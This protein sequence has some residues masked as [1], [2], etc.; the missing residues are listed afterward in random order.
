MEDIKVIERAKR[1]NAVNEALVR[2]TDDL[3]IAVGQLSFLEDI[4]REFL[5][6]CKT[7]VDCELEHLR[8]EWNEQAGHLIGQ[9]ARM[10]VTGDEGQR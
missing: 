4:K 10:G 8:V 1:L 2:M 5:V 7:V 9:V 6:G 3:E